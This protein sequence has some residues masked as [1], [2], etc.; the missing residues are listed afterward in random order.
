M[1]A[2]PTRIRLTAG[3]GFD[4]QTPAQRIKAL[5]NEA[6]AVANLHVGSFLDQIA[7]ALRT[8]EEIV[9]GA[10]CYPVGVVEEARTVARELEQHLKTI[11][12]IQAQRKP[13]PVLGAMS[14]LE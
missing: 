1:N 10:D 5:Q 4:D 14:H 2:Q 12:S 6:A 3:T 8:A 13:I 11:G 9:A 7:A